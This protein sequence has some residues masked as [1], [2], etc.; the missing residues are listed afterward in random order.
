MGERNVKTGLLIS[1]PRTLAARASALAGWRSTA[2]APR[3]RRPNT[4]PRQYLLGPTPRAA[5][6]RGVKPLST[7]SFFGQ[8]AKCEVAHTLPRGFGTRTAGAR[9]GGHG[10]ETKA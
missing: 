7:P 6:R 2:G 10:T 8:P 4:A 5:T 3:G 9:R 1:L